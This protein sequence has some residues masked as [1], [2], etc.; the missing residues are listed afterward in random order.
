MRSIPFVFTVLALGCNPPAVPTPTP[1]AGAVSCA[2]M[3]AHIGP[4]GLNC[5]EGMPVYNSSLP[6]DGGAPNQSCTDF[7]TTQT[8]NG[9]FIN[10]ACVAKVATC[11]GIEAARQ[12]VCN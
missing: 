8:Q 9:V 5:P 2:A 1:A 10:P 3:C 7:C 11:A 4:S 12:Q 6:S